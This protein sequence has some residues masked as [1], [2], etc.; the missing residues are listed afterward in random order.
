ME[1]PHS[2]FGQQYRS[3]NAFLLE[4]LL[5]SA[6]F[7]NRL[8]TLRMLGYQNK[9]LPKKA[10]DSHLTLSDFMSPSDCTHGWQDE[11]FV[12]CFLALFV[13]VLPLFYPLMRARKFQGAK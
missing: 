3:W 1:L 6:K 10:S 12:L 5:V 4:V 7:R 11:H 9:R 8:P 2:H 13:L